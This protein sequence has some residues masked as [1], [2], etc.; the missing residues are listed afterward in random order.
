M[1]AVK[2]PLNF[3]I[4]QG[5]SDCESKQFQAVLLWKAMLKF[6]D[7]KRTVEGSVEA[8]NLLLKREK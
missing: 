5:S 4:M 8:I 2:M 7:D 6:S 1:R 3:L